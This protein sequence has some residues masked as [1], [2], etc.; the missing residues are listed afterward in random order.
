[1]NSTIEMLD[2]SWEKQLFVFFLFRYCPSI[3]HAQFLITLNA[4]YFQ[5]YL[6]S[7]AYICLSRQV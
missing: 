2:L 7:C 3:V 6:D 5:E 4:I 1:M